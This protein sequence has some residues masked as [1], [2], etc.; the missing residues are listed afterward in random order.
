LLDQLEPLRE[1]ASVAVHRWRKNKEQGLCQPSKHS[2]TRH[3]RSRSRVRFH[4]RAAR[5]RDSTRAWRRIG[6]SPKRRTPRIAK[7]SVRGCRALTE[8]EQ[9]QA[10]KQSRQGPSKRCCC[11]ASGSSNRRPPPVAPF[12]AQRSSW[13]TIASIAMMVQSRLAL[14]RHLNH[15]DRRGLAP[16]A[17][18]QSRRPAFRGAAEPACAMP[19]EGNRPPGA[20]ST[21]RN[22]D[23]PGLDR[24][25]GGIRSRKSSGAKPAG[26]R[27]SPAQHAACRL[28]VGDEQGDRAARR[29]ATFAILVRRFAL[30]GERD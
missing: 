6:S 27:M 25:A 11:M 1:P 29:G 4:G 15:A 13:R 18:L 30:L 14:R 12:D 28:A 17:R 20:S 3:M 19:H 9:R 8:A 16:V 5:M 23:E 10:P 26:A 2:C 7:S 22:G 24:R 21:E